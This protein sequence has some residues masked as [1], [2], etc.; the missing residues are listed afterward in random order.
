MQTAAPMIASAM[1]TATKTVET[2]RRIKPA[3]ASPPSERPGRRREGSDAPVRLLRGRG[4]RKAGGCSCTE[5]SAVALRLRHLDHRG[6]GGDLGRRRSK[7]RQP[8]HRGPTSKRQGIGP[9]P[10]PLQTSCPSAGA[11]GGAA[12]PNVR[13]PDL[14]NAPRRKL[15]P[16]EKE[17]STG[18]IECSDG[19]RRGTRER[20]GDR[21][22]S[23]TRPTRADGHAGSGGTTRIVGMYAGGSGVRALRNRGVTGS[24]GTRSTA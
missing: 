23:W 8:E 7:T 11:L 4:L 10:A 16:V 3:S 12:S 22:R 2:I 9:R 21:W 13:V 19:R 15:Q 1:I 6:C 18:G 20:P 17:T 5:R 24:I 14:G